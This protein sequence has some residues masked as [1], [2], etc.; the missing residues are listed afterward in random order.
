LGKEVFLPLFWRE[1]EVLGEEDFRGSLKGCPDKPERGI[2]GDKRRARREE[3][4]GSERIM[5]LSQGV[6]GKKNTVYNLYYKSTDLFQEFIYDIGKGFENINIF[7]FYSVGAYVR[8]KDSTWEAWCN[9]KPKV[10]MGNEFGDFYD[11][12]EAFPIN[13]ASWEAGKEGRDGE[14]RYKCTKRLPY[15]L[16]SAQRMAP[17]DIQPEPELSRI[18]TQ[19]F[20]GRNGVGF[21]RERDVPSEGDSNY[22]ESMGEYEARRVMRRIGPV[23]RL[24]VPQIAEQL[25]RGVKKERVEELCRKKRT[26]PYSVGEEGVADDHNGEGDAGSIN[27][28]KRRRTSES[29]EEGEIADTDDTGVERLNEVQVKQKRGRTSTKD[30]KRETS[31]EDETEGAVD[32][33]SD[34]EVGERDDQGVSVLDELA[35]GGGGIPM[36]SSM[37][38]NLRLST[39]REEGGKETRLG[40]THALSSVQYTPTCT[41]FKV[42]STGKFLRKSLASKKSFDPFSFVMTQEAREGEE[43]R[44]KTLCVDFVLA[45]PPRQYPG[46]D[47]LLP[48]VSEMLAKCYNKFLFIA[49]CMEKGDEKAIWSTIKDAIFSTAHNLTRINDSRATLFTGSKTFTSRAHTE[50]GMIREAT[51]ERLRKAGMKKEEFFRLGGGMA[52][53]PLNIYQAPSDDITTVDLLSSAIDQDDLLSGSVL[54]NATARRAGYNSRQGQSYQQLRRPGEAGRISFGGRHFNTPYFPQNRGFRGTRGSSIF[55]GGDGRGRGATRG[56]RGSPIGQ[57]G[58]DDAATV[59]GD[60]PPNRN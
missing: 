35:F 5:L 25:R 11:L 47:P 40:V 46:E 44:G 19:D 45:K 30:G 15:L 32:E 48:N 1:E 21:V 53:P 9:F 20:F 8:D 57:T 10:V 16:W 43:A 17:H 6:E 23:C 56:G 51:K 22:W 26:R 39:A 4:G 14:V 59:W 49:K 60:N 27:R 18:V 28:L 24:S 50:E 13:I 36:S 29:L 54:A 12:E 58:G 31:S 34:S 38:R 37:R 55:R 42:E 41:S 3:F 7:C 52:D 33:E 2:W